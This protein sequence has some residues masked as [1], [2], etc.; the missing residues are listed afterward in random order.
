MHEAT[1]SQLPPHMV[2]ATPYVIRAVLRRLQDL[3]S[4]GDGLE[5]E[6]E[7]ISMIIEWLDNL[8]AQGDFFRAWAVRVL[9]D[10]DTNNNNNN[11]AITLPGEKGKGDSFLER[12]ATL[13]DESIPFAVAQDLHTFYFHLLIVPEFKRIF[14]EK[15]FMP[16]YK[17][18]IE[19][20]V[21][22]ERE[23]DIFGDFTVQLFTSPN[24]VDVLL[25]TNALETVLDKLY[26]ALAACLVDRK[27]T[28][29]SKKGQNTEKPP[30][31]APSGK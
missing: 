10:S 6:E 26:D 14:L 20:Y 31:A 18:N 24:L 22:G 25:K 11:S 16:F 23:R 12:L 28:P 8:T 30:P 19:S 13:D 1:N 4:L 17:M 9:T 7:E 29:R 5:D 15:H 2:A 27:K 3:M 21:N